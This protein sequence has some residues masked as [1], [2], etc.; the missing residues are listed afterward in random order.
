MAKKYPTPFERAQGG[1][2]A[3]LIDVLGGIVAPLFDLSYHATG[4]VDRAGRIASGVLKTMAAE[5]ETRAG[6]YADALEWAT[7]LWW[8]SLGDAEPEKHPVLEPNGRH[9]DRNERRILLAALAVDHEPKEIA[10]IAG[11]SEAQTTD[12][13]ND[14]LSKLG[15]DPD[16][17]RDAL[18]MHASLESIPAGLLD[19]LDEEPAGGDEG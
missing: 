4:K 9:F 5:I 18:N 19:F 7:A 17:W 16:D 8:T 13:V 15:G 14:V 10:R 12:A 3:A 11:W 1:D 6:T 2:R